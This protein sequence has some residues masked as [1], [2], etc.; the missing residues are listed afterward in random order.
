MPKSKRNK[1][2]SLTKVKKQGKE[3]KVELVEKIQ[4]SLDKYKFCYVL[5]YE[6]MRTS[7]FKQ[8]QHDLKEGKFFLGKNKV[9][10]VALGRTTEEENADNSHLLSKYLKGSVCLCFCNMTEKEMNKFLE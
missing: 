3:A 1:V 9:M 2:I 10:Q 6:N 8:M 5:S 4:E 7:A